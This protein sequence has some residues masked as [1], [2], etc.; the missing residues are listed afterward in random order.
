MVN[1]SHTCAGEDQAVK[2][3]DNLDIEA[4]VS[5][6][7]TDQ[8]FTSI[9]LPGLSSE[10]RKRI[11]KLLEKHNQL[12]CESYG[13]GNERRLHLFKRAT[14]D[15]DTTSHGLSQPLVPE[16]IQIR[17]TFI[18]F[19]GIPVS[20]RLV[21]SMP[22]GMFGQRLLFEEEC[23]WDNS[24]E[25][26]E[27]ST[28]VSDDSANTMCTSS[29]VENSA[30]DALSESDDHELIPGSAVT[31]QGLTQARDFNGLTGVVQS[32]DESLGRYKILLTSDSPCGKSS[33]K[34]KRVNLRCTGLPP[35]S[36]NAHP[37]VIVPV[38]PATKWEEDFSVF[39]EA[40]ARV[41]RA[42]AQSQ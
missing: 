26:T 25:H 27:S 5:R 2:A 10:Q 39:I 30:E 17:N 23:H 42:R 38:P 40:A 8:E 35:A 29:A 28:S 21:Q 31:I 20:E 14:N 3:K 6:L 34:V 33:V 7:L 32:L 12:R 18:H 19:Q 4:L 13:F 37:L 36:D 22:H 1:P 24:S 9:E 41:A 16:E 15:K 11:K